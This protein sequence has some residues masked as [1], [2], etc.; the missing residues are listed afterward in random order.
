MSENSHQS[1]LNEERSTVYSVSTT[2][3]SS[4]A[5][6]HK[7]TVLIEPPTGKK[8][9][10]VSA[11]ALDAEL[12]E[13]AAQAPRIV[14]QSNEN[15]WNTSLAMP[16]DPPAIWGGDYP[17]KTPISPPIAPVA[18][19]F[20]LPPSDITPVAIEH[21]L[22]PFSSNKS[23]NESESKQGSSTASS[24]RLTSPLAT[25]NLTPDSMTT[26]SYVLPLAH[27]TLEDV[28][29]ETAKSDPSPRP[30]AE[31]TPEITPEITPGNPELR[32]GHS[33]GAEKAYTHIERDEDQNHHYSHNDAQ[34]PSSAMS[35][36]IP[37]HGVG[38]GYSSTAKGSET[39]SV[40]L[41]PPNLSYSSA[42][43]SAPPSHL[44][45]SHTSH[46]RPFSAAET[47]TG[48]SSTPHGIVPSYTSSSALLASIPSYASP[49]SS[50]N[51]NATSSV[52]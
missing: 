35:A 8:R 29:M 11:D 15:A 34:K 6:R 52:P 46:G 20:V 48:P 39:R 18:F 22:L 36:S 25:L 51:T 31:L 33:E 16:V 5:T 43:S 17:S 24:P 3:E 12:A 32:D 10:P 30:G 9:V 19:S 21:A 7:A 41:S 49:T 37:I 47:S 1:A 50:T 4:G 45:Y 38:L 13:Y 28:N 2:V 14:S 23:T 42:L 26:Q 44:E 27:V 40:G